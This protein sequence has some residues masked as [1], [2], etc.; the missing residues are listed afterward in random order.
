MHGVG[1]HIQFGN[2]TEI[3]RGAQHVLST[4]GLEEKQSQF[5]TTHAQN[6]YDHITINALCWRKPRSIS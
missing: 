1:C 5:P 2:A 6:K 3:W 4:E